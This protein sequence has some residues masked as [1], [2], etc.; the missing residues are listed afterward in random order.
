MMDQAFSNVWVRALPSELAHLRQFESIG[1]LGSSQILSVG[2]THK[3]FRSV[4]N[5]R[6]I[7]GVLYHG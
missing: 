7:I 2:K 1:G 3:G 5:A 4:T 6:V